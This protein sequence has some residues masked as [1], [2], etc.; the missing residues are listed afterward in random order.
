MKVNLKHCNNLKLQ[1]T[2]LRKKT[3]KWVGVNEKGRQKF[4]F[5]IYVNIWK[6]DFDF[7]TQILTKEDFI[8]LIKSHL[9]KLLYFLSYLRLWIYGKYLQNN[10]A[11][12]NAPGGNYPLGKQLTGEQLSERKSICCQKLVA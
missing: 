2:I 5:I 8:F 11:G 4:L 1:L 7:Q 12:K 9:F 6:R 3:G 10:L